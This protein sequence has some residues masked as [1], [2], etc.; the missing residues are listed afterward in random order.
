[1]KFS[2]LNLNEKI[3]EILNQNGFEFATEIQQKAIPIILQRQDAIFRSETGS[4]KTFAFALP[5]LEQIDIE[6]QDVQAIVI[7]PTRELAIQ[8]ADETKK[9]AEGL[10]IR[11]CAVFGGST[12]TRQIDSLKKKPHIVVGTTGRMMDLIEK[13]ALKIETAN[14]V[15]LDEAD[16]MLDMGFRPD[17]EK[18]LAKTKKEKNVFLFSATMPDDVIEL[19]K[20]YLI[21]PTKVEVGE[22]NKALDKIKQQ[23][24]YTSSKYKKYTLLE[25][26]FSDVYGKCIV[27]VNTKQY[28]EEIAKFLNNNS[29]PCRA[30]H[31]DLRQAERKRVIEMFKAGKIDVL[32]ATDVASR[33]LDIKNVKWIINYDLPH[34]M[35]YYVH[36]IGRTARAGES[37]SV[38]NIITTIGQLSY[39]RD[40]ERTTKAKITLFDTKSENLRQYF[41]DT[42]KLAKENSRF[43]KKDKKN[44][45]KQRYTYFDFVEE[46]GEDENLKDKKELN[47]K[48]KSEKN[49]SKRTKKTNEFSNKFEKHKTNNYIEK[50]KSTKFY[51]N[52]FD[53]E[54]DKKF[55]KHKGFSNRKKDDRPSKFVFEDKKKKKKVKP[56]KDESKWYSK[57]SK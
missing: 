38:I 19:S 43:A 41:V 28:A 25:L 18:I 53:K 49:I 54:E 23:Y 22:A 10:G 48:F 40:I 12:I 55:N 7:C 24:I 5:I 20:K 37:G 36:R 6:C 52:D 9:I 8:V 33:G 46:F 15:V 42:K 31:S 45:G 32:V 1:M 17:I 56:K 16:E 3:V 26:F 51:K 11:V 14:F 13:K 57:F 2:T 30:I 47:S 39:M 27:F 21:N 4:G 50:N 44:Y 35:E 29:T 34:E